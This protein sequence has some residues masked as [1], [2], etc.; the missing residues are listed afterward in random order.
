LDR[1]P[2]RPRRRWR[3]GQALSE[4]HYQLRTEGDSPPRTAGAVWLGTLVGCVPIYGAHLVLCVVLARLLG[5]SRIK[6][7]LAAHINNPFTA[8]WLLVLE[9]GI[10]HSLLGA[11]WPRLD[12]AAL[13]SAGLA[14][15]GRDLILGSLVLGVAL[16]AVLGGI[17]F[18]VSVSARS[19]SLFAKLREE[20]SRRYLDSGVLHWEF[21]RGKL[22]YDPMYRE[23][24]TSGLVPREGQLVDLGCGRGIV[25]ALLQTARRLHESGEWTPALPVPPLHLELA[26]VELRESAARVARSATGG[27]LPILAEDLAGH[28]PQP[29]D[30]ILLLDVLHYLSGENQ[31]GLLRRV[32]AQLRP[33]GLVLV[34]EPDAARGLRFQ[35]SRCGERL[36]AILRLEWRQAFCYRTARSWCELIEGCG[37]ETRV[38]PMWGRTPP[39]NVLIEARKSRT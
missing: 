7:Y 37:L 12:V 39:G 32:A 13:R 17:A 2:P 27:A 16:G 33:G 29:A 22:K 5:L 11:G 30:V 6:T 35:W 18:F 36:S 1:T 31:A 19:E 34:R 10:G 14:N 24:L 9:Y 20:T 25:L 15:L 4:L 3:A 38:S 21:V 23:L 28:D 8:P 26:G